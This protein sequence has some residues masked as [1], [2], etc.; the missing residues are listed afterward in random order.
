M[1][2]QLVAAIKLRGW[3]DDLHDIVLFKVSS[4]IE[5]SLCSSAHA[6]PPSGCSSGGGEG[7]VNALTKECEMEVEVLEGG[8]G[9]ITVTPFT[10]TVLSDH[11]VSVSVFKVGGPRNQIQLN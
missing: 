9:A 2:I 1:Y 5:G 7:V 3:V 8:N 10:F 4:D 11:L 6:T